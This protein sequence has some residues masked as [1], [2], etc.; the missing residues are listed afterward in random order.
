MAH[1]HHTP[2][3]GTVRDHNGAPCLAATRESYPL[4]AVCEQGCLIRCA[5]GSADW[6]RETPDETVD[7]RD[8]LDMGELTLPD[9]IPV[10]AEEIDAAI[11][12]HDVRTPIPDDFYP[13]QPAQ[14]R[15]QAWAQANAP[16]AGID[17]DPPTIAPYDHGHDDQRA[18][19]EEN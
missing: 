16:V 19:S 18:D 11:A 14:W 13:W 15:E 4:T 1:T 8:D 17:F 7:A 12:D 10:T 5:D 3:P 6:T 9:P 2:Q